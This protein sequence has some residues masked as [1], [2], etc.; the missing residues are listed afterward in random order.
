MLSDGK[1]FSFLKGFFFL[2]FFL[3]LFLHFFYK[4]KTPIFSGFLALCLHFICWLRVEKVM[5]KEERREKN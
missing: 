3:L 4:K 5:V 2:F 1:V